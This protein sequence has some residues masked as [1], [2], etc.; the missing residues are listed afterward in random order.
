MKTLKYICGILAATLLASC[1]ITSIAPLKGEYKEAVDAV[2]TAADCNVIKENDRKLFDVVLTTDKN[3]VLTIR[4]VGKKYYIE[5]GTYSPANEISAGSGNYVLEYTSFKSGNLVDPVVS[6]QID[7]ILDADA[8]GYELEGNLWLQSGEIRRIKGY[9]LLLFQPDPEAVKLTNLVNAQV[10]Q[11]NTVTVSLAS[12]GVVPEFDMTTYQW[13]WKGDGNVANIDFYSPDGK[14]HPGTYKPGPEGGVVNEG[15]WGIGWDPGDIYGIGIDFTNWGSIWW[16]ANE[17]GGSAQKLLKGDIIVTLVGNHYTISYVEPN[18]DPKT[19]IMFEYAGTIDALCPVQ[20]ETVKMTKLLN[21][22]DNTPNGTN[23]ITIALG[24]DGVSAAPN[25][26]GGVEY[27]GEGFYITIDIYSGGG[28]AIAEGSYLPGTAGGVI[29]ENQWGIGWDPGDIWGIG[30][31]F[32]NWGTVYWSVNSQGS[33]GTNLTSGLLTLAQGEGGAWKLN[34]AL[35]DKVVT[36]EGP[37][38]PLN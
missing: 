9:V 24:T 31:D 11:G 23:S 34:F 20:V 19:C 22:T 7:F 30:I 16:T 5:T 4:L 13:L 28:G 38:A 33:T 10:N 36:Y 18:D 2:F 21:Y 35:E 15:Q 12:S 3:E 27:S 25:A 26:F 8:I 32:K 17:Q 14:L 37:I 6:G 29:E 1:T